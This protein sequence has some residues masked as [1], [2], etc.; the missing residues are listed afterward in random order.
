MISGDQ[1]WLPMDV[2]LLGIV[3]LVMPLPENAPLSMVVHPLGTVTLVILVH[4]LNAPFPMTFN[5]EFN[6]ME[7]FAGGQSNSFV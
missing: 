7:P 3:T 5:A 2:T 6:A 4:P 1:D